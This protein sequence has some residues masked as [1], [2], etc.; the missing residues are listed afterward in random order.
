MTS[1]CLHHQLR[2]VKSTGS[3]TAGERTAARVK[4]SEAETKYSQEL[5]GV[6]VSV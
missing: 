1:A 6:V 3:A 5:R 2:T 4:L